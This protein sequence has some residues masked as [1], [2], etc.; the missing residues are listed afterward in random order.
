MQLHEI[1]CHFQEVSH[2]RARG[3]RIDYLNVFFLG[4]LGELCGELLCLLF[5]QTGNFFG[6]RLG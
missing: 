3:E 1:R 2:R 6:R 4:E 5:D